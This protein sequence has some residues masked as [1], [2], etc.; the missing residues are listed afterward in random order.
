MSEQGLKVTFE[1]QGGRSSVRDRLAQETV[2]MLTDNGFTPCEGYHCDTR[3]SFVMTRGAEAQPVPPNRL[4]SFADCEPSSHDFGWALDRLREGKLVQRRGWNGKGM[5]L[6]LVQGTKFKVNRP[7]LNQI[8][9]P[10][11]QVTYG[12]HID[13]RAANGECRPWLASQADMM[14]DDW[15]IFEVVVIG[16]E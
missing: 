6:Y 5:F 14:A 7:P 16:G 2:N 15:R 4:V 10:G 9:S 8:F 1:I 11:T 12:S 13:I 3:E